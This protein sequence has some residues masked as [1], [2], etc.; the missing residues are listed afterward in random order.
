M[1]F[2]HFLLLLLPGRVEQ[3]FSLP[4]LFLLHVVVH[5][6]VVSILL[7]HGC[8]RRSDPPTTADLVSYDDDDDEDRRPRP[9]QRGD[10]RS[11]G[12]DLTATRLLSCCCCCCCRRPSA[13]NSS[14]LAA[15][16]AKFPDCLRGRS[17]GTL[18]S[19]RLHAGQLRRGRGSYLCPG[20]APTNAKEL[21]VF[22]RPTEEGGRRRSV[23]VGMWMPRRMKA[24][25]LMLLAL[26]QTASAAAAADASF[27]VVLLAPVRRI[28]RCCNI[29]VKADSRTDGLLKL[30]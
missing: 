23:P 26:K 4:F 5:R 25:L 10:R 2:T 18:L 17:P 7:V 15:A 3:S 12:Y 6:V 21:E 30:A 27:A 14:A 8:W 1:Q 28:R 19:Y 11:V 9:R 24:R 16:A 29:R 20:S 13:S 22:D